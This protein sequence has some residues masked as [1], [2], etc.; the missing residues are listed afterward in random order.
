M[1]FMLCLPY[2]WFFPATPIGMAVLLSA[3]T[4]VMVL[5]GRRDDIIM[6]AI[7]TIVVTVIAVIDPH[8]AWHQPLLRLIDTMV[9]IGIGVACKWLSSLPAGW[10]Q[11]SMNVGTAGRS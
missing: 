11:K 3:G 10:H 8:D 4:I 1:S 5:L 2:L 6:T 7:T 9:G